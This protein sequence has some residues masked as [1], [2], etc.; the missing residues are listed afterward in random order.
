M[1]VTAMERRVRYSDG[2]AA[3]KEPENFGE[4]DTMDF[5]GIT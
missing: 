2:L 1:F 3:S 4:F 5:L